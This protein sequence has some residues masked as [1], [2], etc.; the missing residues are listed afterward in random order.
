M[1]ELALG[2][3]FYAQL[4]QWVYSGQPIRAGLGEWL[5]QSWGL[6]CVV[7]GRPLQR[8]GVRTSLAGFPKILWS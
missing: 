8:E 2:A 5:G 4:G 1:P 6:G 3:G 7:P